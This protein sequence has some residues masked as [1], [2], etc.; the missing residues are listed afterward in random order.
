MSHFTLPRSLA[1]KGATTRRARRTRGQSLVEFA[2][3]LPIMLFL[4][5]IAL[6]FGRIYL[7]YINVQNMA[8]IAA[9]FAANNPDAWDVTPDPKGRDVQ[10]RKQIL[11]DATAI[12]CQLPVVG[13]VPQVP[14][15]TF[16]DSNGNGMKDV[17]ESAL[18]QISCSFGVITPGISAIVGD[19]VKV[20]AASTFPIKQGMT[21]TGPGVG[22]PGSPPNA[23][24]TG[25]G[26][27]TPVAGVP[28]TISGIS[29]FIV[30][31]R[32]TS[33]GVPTA[34]EWTF[35]GGTQ[36][37]SGAPLTSSTAQDPGFVKFVT[38]GPHV[39]I[40]K[41]SNLNG[42][43][44]TSMTVDITSVTNVNFTSNPA[45][46]VVG[47]VGLS[48]QFTDASS[49]GS[50]WAW[51]FGDGGTA[52]TQN[53]THVYNSVGTFDVRL[54]VTYPAPD[55]DV[56]VT[57][58]GYVNIVSGLCTVPSLIGVNFDAASALW[59]APPS[60]FTGTVTKAPGSPSGNFKIKAQTL[61]ANS[62]V[63]CTSSVEVSN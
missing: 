30:E 58:T 38:L 21:S 16:T 28:A 42:S 23:A 51:T 63:P 50:A 48:V 13:G 8:R 12:N 39:V 47:T 22:G 27:V 53:P 44:Q 56:S 34:W 36:V 26:V 49:P 19:V 43:T 45:E 54:T 33:G 1:P 59:Q 46:P 11:A 9:N 18:V 20:S 35:P 6:D 2:L 24:F 31:F 25:N 61:T 62:K 52:S 37:S 57:K 29:P 17:G 55:G 5:L 32:D 10:Y 15:P 14:P 60:N 40:L 4:T 3:V 7:G 41:A